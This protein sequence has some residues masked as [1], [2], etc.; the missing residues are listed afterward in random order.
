M[1][2]VSTLCDLFKKSSGFFGEIETC[3]HYLSFGFLF[4]HFAG[5]IDLV[6]VVPSLICFLSPPE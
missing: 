3:R 2:K 1:S 4:C 6:I 5:E